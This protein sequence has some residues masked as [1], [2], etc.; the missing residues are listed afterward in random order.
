MAFIFVV[1]GTAKLGITV[2]IKFLLTKL[3]Q[4]MFFFL[5]LEQNDLQSMQKFEIKNLYCYFSLNLFYHQDSVH[6]T[7]L[8]TVNYSNEKAV[9]GSFLLLLLLLLL[10]I[11]L[12]LTFLH[13]QLS[14]SMGWGALGHLLAT[15]VV[16]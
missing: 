5:S 8:S 16:L 3:D 9:C 13:P 14:L 7:K 4:T 1:F 6:W 11:L 2:N 15:N 12:L 10:I